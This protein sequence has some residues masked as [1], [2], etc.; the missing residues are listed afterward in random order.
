M[1]NLQ[2][3]GINP[4]LNA[5]SP[6]QQPLNT[7]ADFLGYDNFKDWFDSWLDSMYGSSG[8]PSGAI[9]PIAGQVNV[10]RDLGLIANNKSYDSHASNNMEDV[11]DWIYDAVNSGLDAASNNWLKQAEFN[12]REAEKNRQFQEYMSN[13][14]YQ[15]A[16]AD[17]KKAGINPLLAFNTLSGASTPSGDSASSSLSNTNSLYG[18][19]L[20]TILGDKKIGLALMQVFTGLLEKILPSFKLTSLFTN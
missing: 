12:A 2:L 11:Y 3:N 6:V 19:L 15:R 4:V 17:L 18:N 1:D 10:N 16:V 7:N 13:T 9:Q 20:S 14:S 5:G 8:D